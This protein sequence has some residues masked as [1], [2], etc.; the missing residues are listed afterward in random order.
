MVS[1]LIWFEGSYRLPN[2]YVD[3]FNLFSRFR[4]PITTLVFPVCIEKVWQCLSIYPFFCLGIFTDTGYISFVPSS[5]SF[6]RSACV[7]GNPSSMELLQRLWLVLSGL[8]LLLKL[9]LMKKK[10]PY[11]LWLHKRIIYFG[12]LVIELP[13]INYSRQPCV[14]NGVISI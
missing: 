7:L 4:L 13:F 3:P 5:W 2:R 10:N 9:I 6:M 11:L 1:K 12:K 14:S 8:Q